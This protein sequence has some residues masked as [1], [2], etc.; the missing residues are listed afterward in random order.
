MGC[1]VVRGQIEGE[2]DVRC[3]ILRGLV[4][5]G[6]FQRFCCVRSLIVDERF[7]GFS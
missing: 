3:L 4:V 2:F 6:L 7:G 1:F 5:I